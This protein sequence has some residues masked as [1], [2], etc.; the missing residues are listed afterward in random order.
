M[1]RCSKS[2]AGADRSVQWCICNFQCLCHFLLMMTAAG[3]RHWHEW[4][5][6][7]R[8]WNV[9]TGIDSCSAIDTPAAFPT[10]GR[11]ELL[12]YLHAHADT[13][14]N[15]AW[16]HLHLSSY[17]HGR[18]AT[19]GKEICMHGRPCVPPLAAISGSQHICKRVCWDGFVV[20]Q[21]IRRSIHTDIWRFNL[22]S[23]P[24]STRMN[25]KCWIG[26]CMSAHGNFSFS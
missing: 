5:R 7:F 12:W 6:E 3:S 19:V 26:A 14:R 1:L 2:S 10:R 8:R 9:K 17:V 23:S 16:R 4:N 25:A 22:H 11:T 21:P 13:Q 24:V 15:L 20:Y 18:H